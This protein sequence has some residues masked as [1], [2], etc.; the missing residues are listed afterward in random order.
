MCQKVQLTLLKKK[1]LHAGT[2][3]CVSQSPA[4]SAVEI[5]EFKKGIAC[6]FPSLQGL[7]Q[8][9][10][11]LFF[12]LPTQLSQAFQFQ[13]IYESKQDQVD[14]GKFKTLTQKIVHYNGEQANCRT[15]Q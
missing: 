9:D 10:A 12:V 4:R 15:T 7:C 14:S 5:K 6:R 3:L 1:E 13:H 8:I 2:L 11:T